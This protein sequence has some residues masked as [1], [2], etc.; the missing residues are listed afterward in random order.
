MLGHG[1]DNTFR[2]LGTAER[3]KVGVA[4]ININRPLLTTKPVQWVLT[5]MD[6]T[7]FFFLHP[8]CTHLAE[9]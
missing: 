1:I 5:K 2:V 9:T 4:A 6:G 7:V 3:Q 8:V